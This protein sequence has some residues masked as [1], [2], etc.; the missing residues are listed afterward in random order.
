MGKNTRSVPTPDLIT[1]TKQETIKSDKGV[2]QTPVSGIIES[3]LYVVD[4]GDFIFIPDAVWDETEQKY[5]M[6]DLMTKHG[7]KAYI[8]YQDLDENSK[9]IAFRILYGSTYVPEANNAKTHTDQDPS[10]SYDSVEI[11]GAWY[12]KDT[13]ALHLKGMKRN[14][15]AKSVEVGLPQGEACSIELDENNTYDLLFDGNAYD[16]T[17]Y[18]AD[19]LVTVTL[20]DTSLTFADVVLG[21][22][23]MNNV[24]V[25]PEIDTEN[26]CWK[27]R[28]PYTGARVVSYQKS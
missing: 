8:E 26:S 25:T 13:E 24:T 23:D 21:V 15:T 18:K 22:E 5:E 4:S 20:E 10:T 6:P 1:L 27:F 7:K 14:N 11:P 28:M 16:N 3:R 9:R 2:L 17:D 19:D 12:K